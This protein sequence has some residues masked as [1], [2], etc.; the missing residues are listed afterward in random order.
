VAEVY[1]GQGRGLVT[2]IVIG[3]G[4][5]SDGTKQT[6]YIT[7]RTYWNHFVTHRTF[8]AYCCAPL[9]LPLEPIILCEKPAVSHRFYVIVTGKI[10]ATG[11]KENK[12]KFA[13]GRGQHLEQDV[14]GV[15]PQKLLQSTNNNLRIWRCLRN[16][17]SGG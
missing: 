9:H 2:H 8:S 14:E 6:I 7:V 12:R 4:P 15:E 16:L 5:G 3:F 13:G 17:G 11:M 10:R 1:T